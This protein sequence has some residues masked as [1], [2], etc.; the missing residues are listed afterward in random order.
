[1]VTISSGHVLVPL[2]CYGVIAAGG[3]Y[4]AASTAFKPQEL[5]R[6][7]QQGQS[8]LVIC[9]PDCKDV[10]Q[11]AARQC[12]IPMDRVLVSAGAE[13]QISLKAVVDGR[14]LM[15]GQARKDEMLDWKRI[16][17]PEGL[18]KSKVCLMYSR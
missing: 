5:V 1:M 4:S 14:N 6:Q 10:A 13:K 8:D 3:V 7:I 17:D 2:V 15:E 16:T 12:G 9:S 18:K 11:E